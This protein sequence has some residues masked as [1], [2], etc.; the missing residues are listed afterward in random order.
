MKQISAKSMTE[1]EFQIGDEVT[2]NPYGKPWLCTVTDIE[3]HPRTGRTMYSLKGQAITQTSGLSIEQSA[4]FEE[5][6]ALLRISGRE[7]SLLE[8]EG[9]DITIATYNDGK[10][11]EAEAQIRKIA[12]TIDKPLQAFVLGALEEAK[13]NKEQAKAHFSESLSLGFECARERMENIQS[14]VLLAFGTSPRVINTL[15]ICDK[16]QVEA[17]VQHAQKAN[18]SL[19]GGFPNAYSGVHFDNENIYSPLAD[20]YRFGRFVTDIN[21]GVLFY[22]PEPKR[23]AAFTLG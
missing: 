20:R 2:F 22:E 23:S 13:G 17:A 5:Y 19:V 1:V 6:P 21:E 7:A 8:R 10:F 3:T 4:W 11:E 15:L 9:L 12:Q 16:E 18:L 14:N